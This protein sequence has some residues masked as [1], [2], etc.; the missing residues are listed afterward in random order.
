MKAVASSIANGTQVARALDQGKASLR[1]DGFA[2]DYLDL[3]HGAS[4]DRID[5]GV[6][7]ARILAAARLGRVRLLDNIAV[8]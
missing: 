3:V 8:D 6:A 7:G 4:L 2:V 5:R 1:A